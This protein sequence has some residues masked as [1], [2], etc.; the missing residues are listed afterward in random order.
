MLAM[1]GATSRPVRLLLL[2]ALLGPL[3]FSLWW[4]WRHPSDSAPSRFDAALDRALEPVLELHAASVK[5]GTST[6]AQAKVLARQLAQD[7]APFLAPADLELWAAIRLEAARSSPVTC[8]RL[9]KGGDEASLRQAV[10][11]LGDARLTAWT[12]MLARGFAV[13]LERKRAP[14]VSPS[15]LSRGREAIIQALPPAQQP[16][17]RADLSDRELSDARACQLFLTLS[18]QAQQLEP[19]LRSELYRALAVSL[20]AN[21]PPTAPASPSAY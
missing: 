17:F 20:R 8:A 11:E 14:D 15:A 21:P 18:S 5:L 3:G 12:E 2:L 7:S 16:G 4:F 6:P 9:G 19:A 13:R 10:V 1:A